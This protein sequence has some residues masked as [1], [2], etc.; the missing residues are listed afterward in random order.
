MSDETTRRDLEATCSTF[1]SF[2]PY[3]I[4]DGSLLVDRAA[5]LLHVP[6]TVEV[7]VTDD[8][9]STTSAAFRE[10]FRRLTG[11]QAVPEPVAA[12]VDDAAAWT[13]NDLGDAAVGVETTLLPQFYRHLAA[14]HCAYREDGAVP[15]ER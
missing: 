8:V 13:A 7:T 12:A 14:F 4:E 9:L 10:S 6:M 5:M 15:A 1:D 11:H 3:G 2:E